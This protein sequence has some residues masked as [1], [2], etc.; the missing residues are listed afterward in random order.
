LRLA[1]AARDGGFSLVEML[2]TL[3]IILVLMTMMY[4]FSSRSNQIEQKKACQKNMQ[5]MYVALE[6]FATDHAEA[7]PF[8]S[9]SKTSEEPLSLLI[10]RYTTDSSSFICPGSRDKKL[11]QGENFGGRRI[12]Y[13]Y[14]MGRRVDDGRELLM[15]DRQVDTGPKAVKQP[16]FSQNGRPPGNNHHRYGGNYLFCDGSM[17]KGPALATIPVVLSTNVV[18]LNPK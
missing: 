3:A 9:G 1:G 17:E 7:F 8:K 2:I 6:I 11:P 18:L 14:F 16:I 13:A 15:T 4:G 5:V 12:S 10:P